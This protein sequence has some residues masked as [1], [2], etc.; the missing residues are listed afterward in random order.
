M[1]R[2]TMPSDRAS[3][4]ADY[5]AWK[6]TA[7]AVL[8]ERHD[9]KPGIIPERVWKKVLYRRP[10]AAGCSRPGGSVGPQRAIAR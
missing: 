7:G 4:Q 2:K 6:I 10:L 5:G 8:L 1:T 9:V 3:A